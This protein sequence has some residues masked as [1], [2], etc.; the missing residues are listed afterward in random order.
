MWRCLRLYVPSPDV[1][2][3]DGRLRF[4]NF[5]CLGDGDDDDDK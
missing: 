4:K 1:G 2:C 5:I 3:R